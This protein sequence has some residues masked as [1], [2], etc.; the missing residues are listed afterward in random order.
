MPRGGV[1]RPHTAA[2][3]PYPGAQDRGGACHTRPRFLSWPAAGGL[4]ERVL[5]V[6]RT[7]WSGR[8]TTPQRLTAEM[9]T[10]YRESD[11]TCDSPRMRVAQSAPR[12]DVRVIQMGAVART[13]CTRYLRFSDRGNGFRTGF[14]SK[15]V[16]IRV[17]GLDSQR[18]WSACHESRHGGGNIRSDEGPFPERNC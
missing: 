8:T 18:T 14:S 3:A 15:A 6:T 5:R 12:H 16:L 4:P 17:S 13:A 9:L 11:G 1:H 2:P 7:L 10:I